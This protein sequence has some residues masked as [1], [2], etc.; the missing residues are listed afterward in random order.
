[1]LMP[2]VK[3]IKKHLIMFSLPSVAERVS[4]R[5]YDDPDRM[6]SVQVQLSHVVASLDKTLFKKCFVKESISLSGFKQA[7]NS[8]Y[9]SLKK[10]TETLYYWKLLSRREFLET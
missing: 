2:I 10:S 5:F 9:K 1:M 3:V 8:V 4:P 7:T 6:I